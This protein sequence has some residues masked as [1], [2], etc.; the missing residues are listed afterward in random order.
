M[1]VEPQHWARTDGG[2]ARPG[3]EDAYLWLGPEDT[4]GHGYLWLVI[5]G[6][7][8]D[9]IGDLAAT[10]FALTVR[11]LYDDLLDMHRNPMAALDVAAEEAATRLASIGKVYPSLAGARA[12]FAAVAYHDGQVYTAVAGNVA[13]YSSRYGNLQRI[14][15]PDLAKTIAGHG[16]EDPIPGSGI[17]TDGPLF[18]RGETFADPEGYTFLMVTD[19]VGSM[20]PDELLAQATARLGAKDCSEALV[21]L[22]RA[23]WGDDD[24]TAVVVRFPGKIAEMLTSREAFLDWAAAGMTKW[25]DQTLVLQTGAAANHGAPPKTNAVALP[26]IH[27]EPEGEPEVVSHAVASTM[28]FSPEQV[29][30]IVAASSTPSH[31]KT[32]VQV[33]PA[34]ASASTGTMAFSPAE[35]AKIR[36]AAEIQIKAS[37]PPA[38][39]VDGGTLAFASTQA[40]DA[41]AVKAGVALDTAARSAQAAKRASGDHAAARSA[42][43]ESSTLFFSPQ[44]M[45]EVR[46]AAAA[47]AAVSKAVSKAA[48]SGRTHNR[49]VAPTAG[50]DPVYSDGSDS[51]DAT[52]M[53]TPNTIGSTDD[54]E[55]EPPRRM[56]Q[57][58][59]PRGGDDLE[60]MQSSK[61]RRDQIPGARQRSVLPWVMLFLLVAGCIALATVLLR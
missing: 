29:R 4:G 17:G 27:G 24:A 23:R 44:Q 10:L 30:A 15:E 1:S 14:G 16:D 34:S 57:I 6:E 38:D 58:A 21:E 45:D 18:R 35:M 53:V 32:V 43:S 7:G 33:E 48:A 59:R 20:V 19:G 39:D 61:L 46:A 26:P 5:D 60:T 9:G 51:Y 31:E 56:P 52:V 11:E 36:G 2:T 28:A 50:L 41:N 8:G 47:E 12:S 13:L 49:D 25:P 40:F 22:S 42:P 55:P 3:N 37:A 54:F